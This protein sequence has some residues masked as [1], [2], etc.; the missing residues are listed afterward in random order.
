MGAVLMAKKPYAAPAA[1]DALKDLGG[2]PAVVRR[3]DDG[4]GWRRDK[5]GELAYYARKIEPRIP[6]TEEQ[7]E[8]AELDAYHSRFDEL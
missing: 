8:E 6:M 5:E 7:R 4:Y 3:N 1:L 2:A